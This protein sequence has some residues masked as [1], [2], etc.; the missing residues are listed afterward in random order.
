MLIN[1]TNRK[2]LAKYLADYIEH[3]RDAKKEEYDFDTAAEFVIENLSDYISEGLDAYESINDTTPENAKLYHITYREEFLC[4]VQAISE[5]DAIDKARASTKWE[6]F[7]GDLWPE[8]AR[9][10]LAETV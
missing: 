6:L 4:T 9:C 8:F 5:V 10:E 2:E 3:E 7:T 1:D